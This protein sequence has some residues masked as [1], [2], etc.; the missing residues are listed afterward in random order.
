MECQRKLSQRSYYKFGRFDLVQ[1]NSSIPYYGCKHVCNTPNF[2]VD[3]LVVIL[4]VLKILMMNVVIYA[5]A[6]TK[7]H[8]LGLMFQHECSELEVGVKIY[9]SG[10]SFCPC[11]RGIFLKLIVGVS[12]NFSLNRLEKASP[13]HLSSYEVKHD[14]LFKDIIT[15][16]QHYFIKLGWCRP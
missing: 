11:E 2:A 5:W 9:I 15:K 12:I 3:I 16:A 14:P 7:W 10:T 4:L 8:R 13:L 1:I 6:L